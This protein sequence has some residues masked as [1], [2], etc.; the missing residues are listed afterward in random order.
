MKISIALSALALLV[1]KTSAANCW[2]EKYGYPCCKNSEVYYVDEEGQWGIEN[3]DWCGIV[4]D[5]SCWSS[6]LGYPCCK[7]T[8]VI[9][10]VDESGKWGVENGDW[11]GID[12]D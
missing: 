6:A 11:C 10:Y 12:N 8:R 1:A 2:S 4:A 7:N 9:Q 3:D 5:G